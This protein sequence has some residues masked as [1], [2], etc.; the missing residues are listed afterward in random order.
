[1]TKQKYRRYLED[2]YAEMIGDEGE[3]GY[4]FLLLLFVQF[5]LLLQ[6]SIFT[7]TKGEKK[8]F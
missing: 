8:C 3:L 2:E 1:M 6:L 4:S 5:R 7:L